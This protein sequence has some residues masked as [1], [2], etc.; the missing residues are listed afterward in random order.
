[1]SGRAL[2]E[3]LL[4]RVWQRRGGL[5][6]A[7]LPLSLLFGAVVALRRWAYQRGWRPI[8]S[9]PVPVVVVGN[10]IAG[11]AGKT[12]LV[13]WL[14]QHAREQGWRPGVV[15]RGHG[16]S[17]GECRAVTSDSDPSEVGDEPLLIHRSTGVP[18]SVG[19]DRQ[20][21]GQAL[22]T[23]HPEVDV[24]ICDDGLQHLALARDLEICV[25]D[26]RGIGNGRL[27][28]AGPLR[29][30]WPRVMD[31]AVQWGTRAGD[32]AAIAGAHRFE[33]RL[34]GFARDALGRQVALETLAGQP[35]VAV[36]GIAQP[37]RFFDD[38]RARGLTLAETQAWP[39][40][41]D[42]HDWPAPAGPVVCTE[43]D[44]VK[45][46]R[47]HPAVLAVPLELVP[48]TD[49]VAAIDAQLARLRRPE[50]SL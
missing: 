47:R 32:P 16:R 33:R 46:W 3:Q 12:P 4:R 34:A 37:E 1:M 14:V 50:R 6:L 7:L 42:F 40:H 30:P 5:A 44:A 31:L 27:L 13:V 36:T 23:R 49:F 18:V 26:A 29:E 38:L 21:A 19:R 15:S 9:L 2:L 43:K 22:L 48:G 35:L 17:A 25:F 10:V 39:D 20:A 8:R 28:P 41:H 11:G 24:V 45:L